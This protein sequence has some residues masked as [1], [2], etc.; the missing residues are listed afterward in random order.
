MFDDIDQAQR[1]DLALT[2]AIHQAGHR[3][4][5]PV[6]YHG[7]HCLDCHEIIPKARRQALPG[8][9]RCTFCQ[10]QKEAQA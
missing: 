6:L 8:V 3:S 5:L 7:K 10:S 9:R 4:E 1:I 2:E